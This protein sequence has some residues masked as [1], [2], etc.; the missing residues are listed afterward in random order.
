MPLPG[1][2]TTP[3]QQTALLSDVLTR[4]F[5]QQRDQQAVELGLCLAAPRW[6][7]TPPLT[8]PST[9]A[10][11]MNGTGVGVRDRCRDALTE[12]AGGLAADPLH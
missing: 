9:A 4:C 1:L 8:P 12:F 3:Q 6:P 5:G 10:A 2:A 11:A 7:A